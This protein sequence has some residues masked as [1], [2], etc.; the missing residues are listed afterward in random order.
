MSDN[1]GNQS[2]HHDQQE[3][4]DGRE[5]HQNQHHHNHDEYERDHRDDRHYDEDDVS[6]DQRQKD[7]HNYGGEEEQFSI[8]ISGDEIGYK[9]DFSLILNS[10]CQSHHNDQYFKCYGF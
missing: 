6:R 3:H 1:G 9:V 8:H 5:D 10:G 7:E 2:D 4:H